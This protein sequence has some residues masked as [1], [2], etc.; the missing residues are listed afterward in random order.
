MGFAFNRPAGLMTPANLYRSSPMARNILVLSIGAVLGGIARYLVTHYFS[1]LS[2]HSG[3][4]IGTLLV[5]VIGSFI[6]GYVLAPSSDHLH[7]T[8]RIF[9]ATGF[10]G[11][12]TTFSAFAYESMMYWNGGRMALLA[13]NVLANNVLALLAVFG[14]ISVRSRL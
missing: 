7:D 11:A 3:F 12:F 5:N 1:E 13:M 10:C 8:W 6:V 2:H 4:P 14:G 9:A